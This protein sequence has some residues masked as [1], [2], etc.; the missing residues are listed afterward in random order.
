M[1]KITKVLGIVT[2]YADA[3]KAG[4]KG[5]KA[6]WMRLQMEAGVNGQRAENAASASEA[7]A[8]LATAR[9]TDAAN[10][11]TAAEMSARS[12]AES[13]A[14]AKS[15]E[16]AA[17]GSKEAAKESA[18]AAD[19]SAN[20]SEA[21][22]NRA[23]SEA[24]RAEAAA[25]GLG[26][27]VE[28][29]AQNAEAIGKLS[30]EIL[31]KAPAIECTATGDVVM[32]SDASNCPLTGLRL[33]GKT[34]QD[35]TPTPE[36]PVDLVNVGEAGSVGVSVCGKNLIPYPYSDSDRTVNGITNAVNA[37]GTVRFSGVTTAGINFYFVRDLKL[38][39]GTYKLTND[40]EMTG[41]KILIYDTVEKV[42][43]A[44][45]ATKAKYATFAVYRDYENVAIYVNEGAVGVSL[46]GTVRP[47][48]RYASITDDTYE[49]YTAQTLTAQTPNGLPGIPVNTGGNYTD[50]DGQQW[51]CDEIDMGRGV[52]VHRNW[53]IEGIE[54]TQFAPSQ[55]NK[56]MIRLPH[57][58]IGFVAKYSMCSHMDY[59]EKAVADNGTEMGYAMLN[60]YAY[61]RFG[62][63]S[64]IN[65]LEAANAWL[66][67]QKDRG[68][69]LKITYVLKEPIETPLT[70]EEIA[71][72]QA[73]HTNK[74][75]TTIYNDA[76]AGMQAD[77]IVDTKLYIDQKIAA[78][79]AAVLN[80]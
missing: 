60:N 56:M 69:P 42:V 3:V 75:N 36:T 5:T 9:A 74:P 53:T 76:G 21:S 66:Q 72:Y 63:E 1:D 49:P 44:E 23:G 41:G 7:S 43:L 16:D 79:A 8:Q 71:A 59:N 64:A 20:A 62:S 58:T 24:N 39:V 54:A 46:S 55:C 29:V 28:R 31:T 2:A 73:L 77:Y 78:I 32:I 12:A 30:E 13:S 17:A 11:A 4:F 51:V 10:S 34:T 48:L 65:S 70:A 47:M 27:S 18:D 37:D 52:Y 67:S 26:D 14:S 6:D 61:L 80:N 35:G 40:G 45:M 68:T 33:Y 22:A 15:S 25:Q 50:A 38:R 19:Q 57:N